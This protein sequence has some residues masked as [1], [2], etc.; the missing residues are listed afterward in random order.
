MF[1][2]DFCEPIFVRRR[3]RRTFPRLPLI[4]GCFFWRL[5]AILL[6]DFFDQRFVLPA[7]VFL[8]VLIEDLVGGSDLLGDLTYGVVL[9][10]RPLADAVEPLRHIWLFFG[11]LLV[12]RF[13]GF[14]CSRRQVFFIADW[15]ITQVIFLFQR[16]QQASEVIIC[17]GQNIAHIRIRS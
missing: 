12:F 3:L 8:F 14:N 13:A 5:W 9:R 16:M 6:M 1:F 15:K 10:L 11:I 4:R 2:A 7:L 17:L